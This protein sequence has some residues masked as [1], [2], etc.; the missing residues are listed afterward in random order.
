MLLFYQFRLVLSIQKLYLGAYIL[1]QK[2]FRNIKQKNST[3]V[4][5]IPDI[6]VLFY[7]LF[8]NQQHLERQQ[9]IEIICR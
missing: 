5:I 4:S 8:L 7:I 6:Y 9:E 1:F 2:F 3:S